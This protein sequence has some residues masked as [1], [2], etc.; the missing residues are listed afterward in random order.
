MN[1]LDTQVPEKQ[2]PINPE[3]EE[4]VYRADPAISN[5]DC[6]LMLSSPKAFK[7][8]KD[9]EL[10]GFTSTG[11]KMGTALDIMILTPHIWESDFI[12]EPADMEKPS[13]PNQMGFVEN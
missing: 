11:F 3:M 13:S 1:E 4:R 12:L 8:V 5:S 6:S 9:G 7:G 2:K 10:E